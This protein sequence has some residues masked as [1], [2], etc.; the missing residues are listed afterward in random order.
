MIFDIVQSYDPYN[1]LPFTCK[2]TMRAGVG[3]FC[4][5]YS[6]GFCYEY[7]VMAKIDAIAISVILP[8]IGYA[9]LGA[10][11]PGFQWYSAWAVRVVAGLL[12]ALIYDLTERACMAAFRYFFA[13]IPIAQPSENEPLIAIA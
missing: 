4:G 8:S 2:W 10:F 11:M 6:L 13:S 12:G 1:W 9:G 5:F 3:G 7:G